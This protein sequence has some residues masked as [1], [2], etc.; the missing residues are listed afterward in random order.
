LRLPDRLI[1][2]INFI[3]PA[4]NV[5]DVGTDHA[6][7]PVY[8]VKQGIAARVI[9]GDLNDGPLEAARRNVYEA[10]LAGEISIRQGYG[11]DIIEP[12]EADIAVIAGMGGSTI[13]EIIRDSG[14]KAAT[15]KQLVLQPMADAGPLREWLVENGWR[16]AAEEL[17]REDNR[18]YEIISA[19]PG[20][21]ETTDRMLIAIGPRL[22]EQR[23]PLLVELLNREIQKQ[24]DIMSAMTQSKSKH[25]YEKMNRISEETKKL[26]RIV[27]CLS[28]ARQ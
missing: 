13:R 15:L 25:T 6:L 12:G 2:I 26:E 8:L 23:N 11:L 21:E 10:G 9:A 14:S 16:I 22:F 7:L 18:I 28:S 24:K 27:E 3:P 5:A 17:V 4:S 1:S 20:R 19:V